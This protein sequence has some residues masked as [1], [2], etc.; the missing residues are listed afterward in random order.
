MQKFYFYGEFG[1]FCLFIVRFLAIFLKKY[2]V[3]IN[4]STF[5]DYSKMLLIYFPDNIIIN[6]TI[7]I[8]KAIDRGREKNNLDNKLK[9]N[10]E[11][12]LLEFLVKFM[13]IEYKF[14]GDY[15]N[16][17]LPMYKNNLL[18]DKMTNNPN[19]NTVGI[20]PR[21]R[22]GHWTHDNKFYDQQFW[23]ETIKYLKEKNYK[24][25]VFGSKKELVELNDDSLY[26]PND[27]EEQFKLLPNIKLLISPDSGFV[28]FAQNCNTPNIIVFNKKFI[29][30]NVWF[31]KNIYFDSNTVYKVIK[32][33]NELK[34]ELEKIL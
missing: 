20:F 32:N 13:K 34:P 8:D 24:I 15:T 14:Q 33:F 7:D 6:N 5:D 2:N 28:T 1:F 25:I 31:V 29:D 9:N 10:E 16:L 26:Y 11:V 17:D 21:F 22:K 19:S 4:L 12:N 3:K 23:L 27:I 18:I 30:W